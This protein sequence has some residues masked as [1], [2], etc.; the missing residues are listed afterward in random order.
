MVDGSWSEEFGKCEVERER[1][2]CSESTS[3]NH[4]IAVLDRGNWCLEKG[5]VEKEEVEW[6]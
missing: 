3:K 5:W 6:V 4:L 2:R 1:E